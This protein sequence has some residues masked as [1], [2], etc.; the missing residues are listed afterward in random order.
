MTIADLESYLVGLGHSVDL[1]T[2]AD[3]QPYSV[4]RAVCITAGPLAGQTCD[5]A[6]A[7]TESA[8]YLPPPAV[9]T[10][11]ALVSMGTFAAQPSSIGPDWQYLSRR[12]DRPATPK[13]IWVHILTI[14]A[15]LR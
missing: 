8:P 6:I 2:G 10:R 15:E 12:Y 9:H 11:P 13:G 4:I 1:I 5:I 3:G 14:L 7:R